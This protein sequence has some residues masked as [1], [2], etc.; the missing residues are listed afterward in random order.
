MISTV[1][2]PITSLLSE[3][4]NKATITNE[5]KSA[6]FYAIFCPTV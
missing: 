3:F 1:F 2:F 5:Y 4:F 6:Y